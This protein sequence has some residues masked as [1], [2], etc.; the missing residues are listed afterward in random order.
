MGAYVGPEVVT[1]GLVLCLDAANPKSYSGT[2]TSWFDVSSEQNHGTLVNSPVY[3][4]DNSGRFNFTASS[5]QYATVQHTSKLSDEIFSQTL[6]STLESWVNVSTFQNWT[7]MINQAF[8]ASYSNT[9]GPGLW[10]NSTGYQFVVAAGVNS[11]P[12]GGSRTLSYTANTNQWYHIAGTIQGTDMRMYVNGV[13]HQSTTTSILPVT[14][15]TST[16]TIGK[17]ATTASPSIAGS[18]SQI[19]IYNRPLLATEILQNFNATRG[20]FGI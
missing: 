5:D 13:L 14:S 15:N 18:L 8:G 6:F 9:T 20:R 1:N 19:R 10:S 12:T 3:S 4:T 17:R 7:C 16:I 11:N 2:G